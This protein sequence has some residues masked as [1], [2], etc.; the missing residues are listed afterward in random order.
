MSTLDAW[1]PTA[2][3]YMSLGDGPACGISLTTAGG[4]IFTYS[5][6]DT[7]IDANA[8]LWLQSNAD[9][10]VVCSAGVTIGT[11]A[12]IKAAAGGKVDIWA[13]AA[14][15]PNVGGPDGPAGPPTAPTPPCGG[16]EAAVNGANA[17]NGALKGASDIYSGVSDVAENGI[18]S[19]DGA[20]GAWEAAKGTWD[21]AKSGHDAG[22][23][24]MEGALGKNTMDG[25]EGAMGVVDAVANI[26]KGDIPNVVGA[27]QSGSKLINAIAG[28]QGAAGSGGGASGGAGG[29][30][31][32]SSIEARGP[33]G[34]KKLTDN[35][36]EAFV[37]KKI[38]YKAGTNIVMNAANKVETCSMVFEAHANIAATM[39]GLARAKVESIGKAVVDGKV[40]FKIKTDGVGEIKTGGLLKITS[41]AATK[42]KAAALNIDAGSLMHAEASDI[43]LNGTSATT[44]DTPKAT[45]T[46]DVE[47]AKNLEVKGEI[48]GMK[49][50]IFYQ[51]VTIKQQVTINAI[52]KITANVFLG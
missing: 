9:G 25:I 3:S 28:D 36:M 26:A 24:D 5:D 14:T 46:N 52:T 34:I 45:F 50:A 22:I 8:S 48:K 33:A 10:G 43:T 12:G 4:S 37:G 1:C 16:T 6:I 17:L 11:P 35:N 19:I 32:G 29:H 30:D 31:G 15:N 23:Y 7:N 41:D 21:L 42:M 20:I 47:I 38:E 2:D 27:I 51:Q 18:A 39:K 44:I 49:P 13:G 40:T